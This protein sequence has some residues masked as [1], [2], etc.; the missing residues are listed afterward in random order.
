MEMV[1]RINLFAALD[2]RRPFQDMRYR[3]AYLPLFLSADDVVPD[4]GQ[5]VMQLSVRVDGEAVYEVRDVGTGATV[6]VSEN[7]EE[8]VQS[9]VQATKASR[10][11][12]VYVASSEGLGRTI[13]LAL[14]SE[15]L[16]PVK[17]VARDS[18]EALKRVLADHILVFHNDGDGWNE[19]QSWDW[20]CNC[21]TVGSYVQWMQ[22]D[23]QCSDQPP[24]DEASID[25]A[26]K[27]N[28]HLADVI[29]AYLAAG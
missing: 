21:R 25:A 1:T 23:P 24:L 26:E 3:A 14:H 18:A 8:A 29:A 13:K 4:P 19:P 11:A 7:L 9:A 2:A 6:D 5:R 15:F 12:I 28:D 10:P 16:L 27:H 17:P 20:Y 22:K